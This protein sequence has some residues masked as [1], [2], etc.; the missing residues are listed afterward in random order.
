MKTPGLLLTIAVTGLWIVAPLGL[1]AQT[2]SQT[3]ATQNTGQKNWKDRAEYDLYDAIQKDTNPQTR[4]EKL[5]QWKDKYPS[6]D[7][8]DLRQTAFLTTYAPLGKVQEALNTA[9]E[10]LAANPND[11]AALYYTAFL[12]PQLVALNL[13]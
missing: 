1:Q 9:K 3:P 5:N 12:T 6:S 4:L 13:K 8:S 10:I 2:E 11:F 7:F